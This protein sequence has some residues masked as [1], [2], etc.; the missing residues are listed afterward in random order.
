[1][2]RVGDK[3]KK[4]IYLKSTNRKNRLHVVIW[5]LDSKDK[6]AV[7]QKT[8]SDVKIKNVKDIKAILQ[9]SHGMIEYVERYD[10]FAKF[11][12]ENRIL[13]IGN[14]HL[15]HGKTA[16]SD[17]TLGYFGEGKSKTVVDD[18]Y[19][20]T[21]F[22]KETYGKEI[23]YFLFGHSMGSFM[24][25][26]YLMTYGNA[27]TGAIICGTGYT[28]GI[29][30]AAGTL[31]ANFI[32]LFK[33]K[34]YRSLFLKKMAFGSY[35]KRIS[36]AKTENDW[37]SRNTANVEKYNQDKYCTF[38]FTV[39]GYQTLFDVLKFIQKKENITHIPKKLPLY[40]IAGKEDPVGNYGAGVL[41]VTKQYK[42][43]RIKNIQTKLYENDRHELTNEIDRNMVFRDILKWIEN[44]GRDN[45]CE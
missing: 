21:K 10:E 25:R 14:D 45:S 9:I 35:N 3:M 31:C 43:K 22:A 40:F 39:N 28:P 7:V 2:R 26:R 42:D 30:L 15:G 1:M 37:L 8:D 11:F 36:D 12:N 29:V 5:E 16:A 32:Q 23:P 20:V 18:L 41:K 24:A 27:L 44:I 4:E 13:V 6:N 19:E 34:Q 38:L 33:G 17:E